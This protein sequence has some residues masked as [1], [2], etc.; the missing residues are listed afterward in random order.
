MSTGITF[1]AACVAAVASVATY[2]HDA[3]VASGVQDTRGFDS[4]TRASK[5]GSGVTEFAT[6]TKLPSLG[7]N[8][9]AL[10]VNEDGTVVAGHSFDRSGMLYAVKWT[11]S[12]GRWVINKLPYPGSAAGRAVNNQGDVVGYGATAPRRA[13]LWPSGGGY[14]ALG[15]DS[16]QTMAHGI[17]AHGQVVVGQGPGAAAVWQPPQY[18][19]ENLPSLPEGGTSSAAAVNGDGA[20]VGGSAARNSV[21]A[22]IP[23]RWTSVDGQWQIEALDNRPGRVSAANAAGDLAGQ[24]S[25]PCAVAGG[26]IRAVIWY[27]A[28][29]ARE[30]ATLGGADSWARGLNAAGELVGASTA[31]NGRNTAFFWSEAR[32]MVELPIKA[33]FAAANGLSDVRSDGTRLVVGMD[34]QADAVVWIVRNP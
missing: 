12:N 6:A 16:D 17:S 9:E 3:T 11:L 28:G 21:E 31:S 7:S 4:I 13:V 8:S 29:G 24:V 25:V 34:G 5:G 10:G 33:R 1:V 26:C 23:V 20:I 19:R 30:L 15:C 18:C 22:G 27:A 14:L 2:A 32:G